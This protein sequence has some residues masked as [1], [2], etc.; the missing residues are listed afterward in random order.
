VPAA[1]QALDGKDRVLGIGDGLALGGLADQPLAVIA[2]GDHG[3]RGPRP[4]GVLDHPRRCAIHDGNARVRRAEIDADDFGHVRIPSWRC[5]PRVR[6]RP[7]RPIP[8]LRIPS[9][10]EP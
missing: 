5:G 2:E 8:E 10:T 4:F 6:S 7:P 1:D 9:V 3:R